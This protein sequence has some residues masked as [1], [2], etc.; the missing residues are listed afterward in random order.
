MIDKARSIY[1]HSLSFLK[2]IGSPTIPL[3]INISTLSTFLINRTRRHKLSRN[4]A[5]EIAVR[6]KELGGKKEAL[7]SPITSGE[8][9]A[10]N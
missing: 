6:K 5:H 10:R 1:F 2:K 3:D 7:D 8:T 4:G 9:A